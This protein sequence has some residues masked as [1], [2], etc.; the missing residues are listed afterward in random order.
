[1]FCVRYLVS[2]D[3]QI[4]FARE[5]R[6]SQYI[7]QHKQIRSTCLAAGNIYFSQDFKSIRKI[8]HCSG[9]FHPNTSS[10]VW[11][12]AILV[13]MN[14]PLA[15][16]L[17]VEESTV[18]NQGHFA[19]TTLHEIT[20][21]ELKRLIPQTVPPDIIVINSS[22]HIE[23]S[24]QSPQSQNKT[25]HKALKLDF[26]TINTESSNSTSSESSSS[27]S[28]PMSAHFAAS[29][30]SRLFFT[31]RLQETTNSYYTQQNVS[32]KKDEKK[33]AY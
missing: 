12:L 15:K 3:K 20:A 7:P 25:M 21:T 31:S 30:P 18:D 24:P 9:D 14:A 22:T 19:V 8:D 27:P 28:A 26:S 17:F 32:Q 13:H 4:L 1:M 11:P 10:L 23:Q 5:G 6:P 33:C 16:T 2:T 29:S